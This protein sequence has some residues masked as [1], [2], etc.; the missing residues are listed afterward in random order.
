MN[1]N[2]F[3]TMDFYLAAFLMASS[4]KLSDY[5]REKGF[6]TFVFTEDKRL[7]NLVKEYYSEKTLIEPITHAR[8]IKN[9]KS[10]IH[11]ATISTSKSQRNNNYGEQL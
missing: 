8:A 3:A 1:E 2:R 9:L 7:L 5:Y 4:C 6:T 11:S 10:L